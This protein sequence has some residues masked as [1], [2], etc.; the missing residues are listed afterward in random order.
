MA[1]FERH[2]MWKLPFEIDRT[3]RKTLQDQIVLGLRG[4]IMNGFWKTGDYLPSR[5]ELAHRLG[6]SENVVR[7]ALS[8]LTAERFVLPRRKS[9]CEV[10]RQTKRRMRGHVLFILGEDPGAYHATI[11]SQTL[12]KEL[13]SSGIKC[14]C[15]CAPVF[16]RSRPDYTWVQEE[17][18]ESPDLVVAESNALLAR[19]L[20]RLLEQSG[21]PYVMIMSSF[22]KCGRHCLAAIGYDTVPAMDRF[23][24]DCIKEKVLSVCQFGYGNKCALSPLAKLSRQGI[25]TEEIVAS[26]EGEFEDFETVQRK[27][28]LAMK[29]RLTRGPLC[30]I[31]FFTDDYLAMGAVPVL[32]EHGL[33]IPGDVKVVSL[34]NK[35][36]GPVFPMTLA[37][38]E[39]DFAA[40]A[41]RLAVG[42]LEWFRTGRFPAFDAIRP[43]YVRGESFPVVG[44]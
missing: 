28:V 42:L 2:T 4:G 18:D 10:L 17:L 33:R 13:N 35:G 36:F 31:L 34:A 5:S 44:T 12:C 16:S 43:L 27:A 7:V 38:I 37:R 41:R 24:A 6:V 3:S 21:S 26:H 39:F 32:F 40:E 8:R 23:V 19:G 14:T 29:R 22:F 9:G 20:I 30:E 1:D 15:V 25:A 11:F